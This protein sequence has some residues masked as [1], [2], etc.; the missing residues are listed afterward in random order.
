MTVCRNRTAPHERV[1]RGGA[2][3][4]GAGVDR[5]VE[6]VE[7]DAA[8]AEVD[9]GAADRGG[10]PGVL[11]LGVDDGDLDAPVQRCAAARA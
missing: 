10:Q 1:L 3:A 8:R 5:Q 11:V 7:A 4:V 2:A 6:R 9:V